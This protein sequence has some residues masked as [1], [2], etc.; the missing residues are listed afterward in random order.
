MFAG[1]RVRP[2]IAEEPTQANLRHARIRMIRIREKIANGTFSFADE[3]P[4]Y[5]FIEK[6]EAVVKQRTVTEVCKAYIDSL[7]ARSELAY[8]TIEGY[9]KILAHHVEPDIGD[10]PFASI[11]FSKLE[12]IANRHQGTKKTFNN[13]V[14]A[15]RGAWKYGYKDLPNQQDPALGLEGVRIPKRE[16]P[17]PDPFSIGE[18]ELHIKKIHEQW[19][20]AQGNYDEFRFFTGLRPSEEIA[21]EWTDCDF[22]ASEVA[23]TKAR[24]MGRD[25]AE[26][27]NYVDR[28]IELNPRALKVLL[29]QR[30]LYSRL[31]LA[32]KIHHDRVF[33]RETGE[34][35]HDLQVQYKCWVKTMATAPRMRERDPYS[36]RHSSVTWNLMLGKN[37]LWVAEQHGHSPEVMLRTYAK[38]TKGKTDADI[39]A[40]RRAF[41]FAA[42]SPLARTVNEPIY[43]T[44][45]ENVVAE[46]EGFEPSAAIRPING[47][48]HS[49]TGTPPASPLKS[50]NSPPDLPLG[51]N[52]KRRR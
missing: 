31:K 35:F 32:G 38:W 37:F 25:K 5:R 14:S 29:R 9:R 16:Q 43:M 47:L 30:A 48:Q 50:P 10:K 26:T 6:L 8:S 19:G 33:F 4:D 22:N 2:T 1:K 51:S 45:L 18:A 40:I 3:F 11:L 15:I 36:A 27:K 23:I 49:E 28:V 7:R 34:A 52:W 12:E 20:E 24:V 17:V 39:D 41:G 13:V 21:L 42:D 44:G 46:S